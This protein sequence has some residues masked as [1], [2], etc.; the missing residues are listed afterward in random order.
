VGAGGAPQ[1]AA[2]APVAIT[3]D[4]RRNSRRVML[5]FI[6]LS[7]FGNHSG[8]PNFDVQLLSCFDLFDTHLLPCRNLAKVQNLR[9]VQFADV[10]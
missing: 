9:K 4:N 5:R 7:S 8:F 1:A 10:A 3:A 6:F 2:T